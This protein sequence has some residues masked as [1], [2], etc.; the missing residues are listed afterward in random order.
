MT[1]EKRLQR[2]TARIAKQ[3]NNSF[4]AVSKYSQRNIGVVSVQL[5][6]HVFF[7]GMGRYVKIYTVKP[8][9]LSDSKRES[10]VKFMTEKQS[11]R[12]RITCV[13]KEIE[14][15]NGA[16]GQ[17]V[18]VSV[19]VDD[20]DYYSAS[21]KFADTEK[22]F[23]DITANIGVE[24]QTCT[25]EEVLSYC[26]YNYTEEQTRVSTESALKDDW[27]TLLFASANDKNKEK[28]A[29]IGFDYPLEIKSIREKL[30][31]YSKEVMITADILPMSDDDVRLY[32]EYLKDSYHHEIWNEGENYCN[33]TY[34]IYLTTDKEEKE[35][36]KSKFLSDF[37]KNKIIF[38]YEPES[39]AQYKSSCALG[40]LDFH[41]M[42]VVNAG[43]ITN[44]LL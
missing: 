28:L 8:G 22:V 30:L 19:M 31:N 17:F 25:I 43:I 41:K 26:R 34:G 16:R 36:L 23:K 24:M 13:N 1:E 3:M 11:N 12:F 2:E 6:D 14:G 7:M 18:F 44:L 20:D 42:K 37:Y 40:L 39:E 5:E 33:L 32:E 21:F 27:N 10:F 15:K 38:Y 29:F 4:H 9:V 35:N